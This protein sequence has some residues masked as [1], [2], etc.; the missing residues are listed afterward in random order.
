M[1]HVL[2]YPLFGCCCEWCIYCSII[3]LI[4]VVSIIINIIAFWLL[5]LLLLYLL[6]YFSPYFFFFFIFFFFFSLS[7][8]YTYMLQRHND[9]SDSGVLSTSPFSYFFFLQL[10][11]PSSLCCCCFSSFSSSTTRISDS[12]TAMMTMLWDVRCTA[13]VYSNSYQLIAA[14][15]ESNEVRVNSPQSINYIFTLILHSSMSN[16]AL[17]GTNHIPII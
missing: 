5:L 7:F 11:S 3:P 16:W 9:D 1:S 8:Q 17:C 4:C 15:K 10:T 12:D 14:L 6:F 2:S 13:V